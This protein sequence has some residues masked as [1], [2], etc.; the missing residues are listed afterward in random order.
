MISES[1][2]LLGLARACFQD[3]AVLSTQF[4]VARSSSIAAPPARFD[5]MVGQLPTTGTQHEVIA[6]LSDLQDM[7]ISMLMSR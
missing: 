2:T 4:N 3:T 1:L 7:M 6:L 5:P